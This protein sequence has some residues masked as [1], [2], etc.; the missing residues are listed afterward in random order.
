MRYYYSDEEGVKTKINPKKLAKI[1]SLLDAESEDEDEESDDEDSGGSGDEEPNDTDEAK[2]EG[3]GTEEPG[4][5]EEAAEEEE[6]D[7]AE[8]EEDEAESG[9]E[10]GEEAEGEEEEGYDG[11]FEKLTMSSSEKQAM[12]DLVELS[13]EIVQRLDKFKK[14]ICDCEL[15]HCKNSHIL[16]RIWKFEPIA[17]SDHEARL[18]HLAVTLFRK[19]DELNRVIEH[20]DM[21]MLKSVNKLFHSLLYDKPLKKS[22]EKDPEFKTYNRLL[23]NAEE[24]M[25][26]FVSETVYTNKRE[27]LLEKLKTAQF[28]IPKL[29]YLYKTYKRFEEGDSTAGMQ[30]LSN[31]NTDAGESKEEGA[32]K[33]V[34]DVPPTPHTL[35]KAE[36]ATLVKG[37]ADEILHK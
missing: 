35:S 6:D 4:E 20:S 23:R 1:Q 31:D 27:E 9:E 32:S 28:K 7:A 16:G 2:P 25:Q 36:L 5:E 3:E 13:E 29:L 18:N 22:I 17:N 15:K 24:F 10:E 34:D 14:T 11:P 26:A 12:A 19:S 33:G 30:Q 21:S 37:A 8:E